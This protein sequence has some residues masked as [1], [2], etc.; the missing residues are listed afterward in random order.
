MPELLGNV[1]PKVGEIDINGI[2]TSDLEV[3][4]NVKESINLNMDFTPRPKI[5]EID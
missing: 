1:L 2:E 3:M 5:G 4:P